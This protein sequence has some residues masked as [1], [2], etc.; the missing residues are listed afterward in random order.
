MP[1]LTGGAYAVSAA[2]IIY[3]DAAGLTPQDL[4]LPLI[5]AWATIGVVLAVVAVLRRQKAE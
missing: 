5:V 2:L 4:R 1:L 3:A